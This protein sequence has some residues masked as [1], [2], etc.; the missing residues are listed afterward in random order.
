[1]KV[2]DVVKLRDNTY[3]APPYE[4]GDVFVAA[5]EIMNGVC[6]HLGIQAHPQWQR[7]A[8][9]RASHGGCRCLKN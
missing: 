9:V 5:R 8:L 4:K 3:L 6:G 1:M 2:G 7:G